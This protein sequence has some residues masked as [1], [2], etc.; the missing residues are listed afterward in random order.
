MADKLQ[1]SVSYASEDYPLATKL[2]HRLSEHFKD[3]FADVWIDTHGLRT[4]FKLT[5]QIQKRLDV[6]DVLL[7]VFTGQQKDS[8]S[9]T[10]IEVGYFMATMQRPQIPRPRSIISFYL[11]DRPDALADT[12]GVPFGID[13]QNFAKTDSDFEA[14]LLAISDEHPIARFLD[15]LE[16]Q[17]DEIREKEHFQKTSRTETKRVQ[18][19]TN[20]L[21]DSFNALKD[22]KQDEDNPQRKFVVEVTEGWDA[23]LGELPASAKIKPNGMETTAIFGLP[24]KNYTW[25]EFVVAAQEKRRIGWKDV[26]E[27]VI[28][29]SANLKKDNSQVIVSHDGK[30]LYRVFLTRSIKYLGGRQEFHLYFLEYL[31]RDEFGNPLTTVLLNALSLCCRF[32][33]MFLEFG[34]P[35]SARSI[36]FAAATAKMVAK[37]RDLVKEIN[38]LW[39]DAAAAKL[40][41]PEAWAKLV[42][43]RL[44]MQ[45]V[46]PWYEIESKVRS[47]VDAILAFKSD[48]PE[49]LV[50]DLKAT[51]DKLRGEFNERNAELISE[52]ARRLADI[53]STEKSL[54][55]DDDKG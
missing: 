12:K 6:T 8:H 48:V 28:Q 17:V 42:D 51:I 30:D 16:Q 31:Q 7:V 20:L 29:A 55:V 38:I 54:V 23:N 50:E 5:E 32:R 18:T 52:L 21:R 37:A 14:L 3:D 33:S 27:K 41:D 47:C 44:V 45:M 35:F 1:I 2:H 19:A 10:G 9:F 34:S 25:S 53:T 40:E 4:G 24:F 39:I 49:Y 26:V 13:V 46:K 43:Y 22:R 36:H 15:Q 11:K